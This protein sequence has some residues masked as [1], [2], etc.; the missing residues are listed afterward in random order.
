MSNSWDNFSLTSILFIRQGVT[1]MKKIISALSAVVIFL[2]SFIYTCAE[3]EKNALTE[4]Y[5]LMEAETGTV[6]S[7]E[8]GY[9]KLPCG[10]MNKLMT[11]LLAAEAMEEGAFDKNTVLTASSNA[12]TQ[13]G[14]VIWLMPGEEISVDELLKGLII[15]NAN[16]AAM[17][18]AEK[19][20]GSE[21]EFVGMMNARAFELGMK[22]T[23]YRDCCGYDSEEQYSCAYDI[24]LVCRELIR[25]DAMKGYMTQWLTRIRNDATEVVNENHL[26]RTYEG[27]LGI[28]ACHS[29]KSGF[30]AALAAERGDSRYISICIGSSDKDSRFTKCKELLSSGFSLYKV[31]TPSFSTEFIKPISVH[32]GV[33]SAVEIQAE[34]LSS[35]VV[36]KSGEELATVVFLP[37]Y[38]DAPVRK[39]QKIGIVGFYNGE[40]LLY[41]TDLITSSSI[42][43]MTFKH[44][45]KRILYTMF[46]K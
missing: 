36:P 8:N 17:V 10:S 27:M 24:A 32:G 14:A 3:E 16:D 39:G 21:E 44:A 45:Y 23:V 2:L 25:Y 20:S 40:T 6:L 1:G 18:L 11:M 19:I 30:C 33:D 35:L 4:A 9:V 42:S 26:V 37:E 7:Q 28:K 41:Q 43:D 15:G 34:G 38:L 13:R 46:K 29:E 5:L 12:S 31:T 22:N